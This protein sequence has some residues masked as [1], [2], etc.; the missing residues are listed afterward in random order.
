MAQIRRALLA[1]VTAGMLV[2][3]LAGC[4]DDDG[5]NA[6]TQPLAEGV[7]LRVSQGG[8][9]LVDWTLDDLRAA[10][11]FTEMDLEGSAQS[12]PLFTDVLV[13]AGVTSWETGEVLG[14]GEGR[15]FEVG[16]EIAVGNVNEG[17]ILDVTNRG[18]IKLAAADLPKE[19]W[20]RDVIEISLH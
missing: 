16:L 7:V 8:T 19:Q 2:A 5:A 18:T 6:S 11:A 3:G 4:G 9:V 10:V 15:V 20:V 12:G 13:A 14:L 17:W 1:L